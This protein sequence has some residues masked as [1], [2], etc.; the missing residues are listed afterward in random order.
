SPSPDLKFGKSR[1]WKVVS[2]SAWPPSTRLRQVPPELPL[3]CLE[4]VVVWCVWH[5]IPPA[6]E[7]PV[8]KWRQTTMRKTLCRMSRSRRLRLE[9]PSKSM[10]SA[11]VTAVAPTQL[12]AVEA[13]LDFQA[14]EL[15][16]A[17]PPP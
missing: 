11:S 3:G 6:H 16:A 1:R 10:S 2:H 12:L 17:E 13:C 8:Q 4:R 9:V 14:R 5:P 15:P 7:K